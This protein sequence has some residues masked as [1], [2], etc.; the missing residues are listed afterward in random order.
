M[1][2]E[3]VRL[4]GLP[5]AYPRVFS[6]GPLP[7]GFEHGDGWCDLIETLCA[8][9]NTI[10]QEQPDALIDVKQVKE[11]LG[12]LRFYYDIMGASDAIAV[13]IRQAVELAE[14][15]SKHICERCGYSGN[16][17]ANAGRLRA[18]CD[19]CRADYI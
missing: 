16:V 10:V 15:T 2:E 3:R 19:T 18:L 7:W 13:N 1:S 11:K 9:L 12:A 14:A 5:S 4:N 8:R 17:G 6:T